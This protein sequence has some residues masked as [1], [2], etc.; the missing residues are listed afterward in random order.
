MSP[1]LEAVTRFLDWR[2]NSL[3]EA[4]KRYDKYVASSGASATST[5]L[6]TY[7]EAVQ[8]EEEQVKSLIKDI[9]GRFTPD[10]FSEIVLGAEI[11]LI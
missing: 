6:V 9:E 7:R 8:R 10:E 3:Y 11:D 4:R 2:Y 5:A 1:V